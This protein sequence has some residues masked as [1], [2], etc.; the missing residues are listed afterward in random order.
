MWRQNDVSLDVQ[1]EL[2]GLG[3]LSIR[4]FSGVEDSREK[5]RAAFATDLSLN[6][7]ALAPA[8]PQARIALSSLVAAWETSRDQIQRETQ[9]RAESKALNIL[10]PVTVQ[11]RTVM[12]RALENRHGKLASHMVPSADYLALKTE[13]VETAEPTASTLDEITSLDDTESASLHATVDLTGNLKISRKRGKID[14]PSSSEEFRGRLRVETHTWLMLGLKY[15]NIQW[16]QNLE[17]DTWFAYI[18]YFLGKNVSKIEIQGSDSSGPVMTVPWKA[19]LNYELACRRLAFKQVRD[20]GETLNEALK[21]V[22]KD[23]ECKEVN[24]T[25]PIALGLYKSVQVQGTK[26]P[27]DDE[28]RPPVKQG[29]GASKGAGA[30]KGGKGS[31]KSKSAK[32]SGKGGKGNKNPTGRKAFLSYTPDGRQICFKY[33][34]EAGCSDASCE[35]VHICQVPGC[36]GEHAAVRCPNRASKQ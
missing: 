22:I 25:S 27:W 24:F 3:Y 12:R 23:S 34:N 36:N 1:C 13:E 32:G 28:D 14:L 6:V 29:K 8:G 15:T 20:D 30:G 21:K 9:I 7:A 18:D 17:R 16:L 33:N 4:K 19:V 31:G 5:V 2:V 10:R 11:D 26:R 35:R